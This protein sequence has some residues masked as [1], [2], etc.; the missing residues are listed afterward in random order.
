MYE[1]VNMQQKTEGCQLNPYGCIC[2]SD[3]ILRAKT[4]IFFLFTS[5]GS[6]FRGLLTIYRNIACYARY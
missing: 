6:M 4:I 1:L 2:I 5:V 3:G